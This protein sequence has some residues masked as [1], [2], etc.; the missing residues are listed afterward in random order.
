VFPFKRDNTYRKNLTITRDL[1]NSVFFIYERT[2]ITNFIIMYK[3]HHRKKMKNIL[4][5]FEDCS[6]KKE[7]RAKHVQIRHRVKYPKQPA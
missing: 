7:N 5:A 1:Q 6:E 4:Q 2:L 3:D